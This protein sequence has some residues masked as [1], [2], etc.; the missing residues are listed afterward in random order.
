MIFMLFS[1]Y[2]RVSG[3]YSEP[4]CSVSVG[5]ATR[6]FNFIMKSSPM[7]SSDCSLYHVGNFDTSSGCL[8]SF[9]KPDFICNYEVNSDE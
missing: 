5:V 2:D 7:V 4:F 8:F 1:I 3:T 6:R 9:D